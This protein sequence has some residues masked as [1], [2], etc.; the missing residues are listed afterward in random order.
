MDLRPRKVGLKRIDAAIDALLP[1]GFSK[2]LIC[3][4]VDNLLKV[5]E[6]DSGWV[7]I[8]EASYK[9]VIETILEEQE[10]SLAKQDSC[11][12][13]VDALD[14]AVLEVAAL[15]KEVA[16]I[17][18]TSAD[19]I[20]VGHITERG[21]SPAA[22]AV[23][24]SD[25]ASG[26]QITG[27]DKF[28]GDYDTKRDLVKPGLEELLALKNSWYKRLFGS[29]TYMASREAAEA[30]SSSMEDLDWEDISCDSKK[31]LGN[32]HRTSPNS[33]EP[34]KSFSCCR[35][36]P[37]YG[38]ISVDDGEGEDAEV[39]KF[40]QVST[41]QKMG[42][43]GQGCSSSS[44]FLAL[45]LVASGNVNSINVLALQCFILLQKK[46]TVSARSVC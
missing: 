5:Y 4:T 19:P 44:Q 1:L 46:N 40:P 37:S 38:W 39:Y 2:E 16:S 34:V 13:G 14:A 23:S 33:S 42:D 3:E 25:D 41:I 35:R 22:G 18:G 36:R 15:T 8:E 12:D 29:S 26:R 9:L 17:E 20:I 32:D 27:T 30:A 24:T 45:R 10:K 6:G 31:L 21:E 11:K 28:I 43:F 7:F